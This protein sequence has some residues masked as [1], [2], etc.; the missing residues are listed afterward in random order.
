MYKVVIEARVYKDL[1]RIPTA[2]LDRIYAAIT[3]LELNP[4]R[5]GT[6]K[7]QGQANRYRIRQGDYRIIYQIHE[8][9]K[10]VLVLVVGHRSDVYRN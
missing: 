4:R 2:D 1:D 3:S 6:Q 5:S 9:E 8:A 10:T 7:L